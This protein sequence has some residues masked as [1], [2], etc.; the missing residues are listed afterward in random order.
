MAKQLQPKEDIEMQK[1]TAAM[2][3]EENE[4][5]WQFLKDKFHQFG[6]VY[7]PYVSLTRSVGAVKNILPIGEKQQK[8]AVDN[9]MQGPAQTHDFDDIAKAVEQD[10]GVK[11]IKKK[12]GEIRYAI[13]SAISL[14]DQAKRLKNA[15]QNIINPEKAAEQQTENQ[16][17]Q[18][19]QD[20]QTSGQSG[21]QTGTEN[22]TQFEASTDGT[23][24]RGHK[25][26][27]Q[28]VTATAQTSEQT[29]AVDVSAEAGTSA[30]G[31]VSAV[32]QVSDT[33]QKITKTLDMSMSPAEVSESVERINS[34]SFN[35]FDMASDL[36]T[37]MGK[38]IMA[39]NP[40]FNMFMRPDGFTPKTFN[41]AVDFAKDN[42]IA[43]GLFVD[44]QD[45]LVTDS[46]MD[47][48]MI[49][50]SGNAG[51]SLDR[52]IGLAN[53]ATEKGKEAVG[54]AMDVID[55]VNEKINPVAGATKT[56][57]T[58]LADRVTASLSSS[59][60]TGQVM[61]TDPQEATSDIN[62]FSHKMSAQEQADYASE[63]FGPIEPADSGFE[64]NSLDLVSG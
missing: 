54:K 18:I 30:E 57:L 58:A 23:S 53:A 33:E 52:I 32:A 29:A 20:A 10:G 24:P 35:L 40:G 3:G 41:E 42:Y 45:D 1:K 17:D 39:A 2:L 55:K 50:I 15:V 8:S 36:Q 5:E 60:F 44:V 14:P 49:N 47:Q 48:K 9:L 62:Q 16:P 46:N 6:S 4:S 22:N 63:Q 51:L 34:R 21:D 43:P 13:T 11:K 64:Y 27:G 7:T 26:L 61:S 56:A 38:Q 25:E 59:A 19:G 37:K 28:P 12:A 31:G